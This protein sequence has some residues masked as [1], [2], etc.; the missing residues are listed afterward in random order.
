[1]TVHRVVRGFLGIA[2][3]LFVLGC[4]HS[5]P[6]GT[7]ESKGS[8][9][10]NSE[11][12][13]FSLKLPSSNWKELA[14]K[15]HLADFWNARFGSPM[16]AGVFSV[17]KQTKDEF[18]DLAKAFKEEAKKDADLLVKP[19]IQ[20]GV[21]EVGNAYIF[22]TLCEKGKGQE[23][24]IYVGRAYT[25]LKDKE[26]TV[27]VFFEGQGKMRSKVFKSIEYSEFEKAAKTICL[28]VDKAKEPDR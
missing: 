12:N 24:Y 15:K 4:G 8:W 1:M 20:E 13:G 5:K 9:V 2:L 16:L 18:E 3:A 6:A 10:Y 25:W 19:R 27:E 23:Q 21:N 17:K 22:E 11:T 7:D 28:S 14:K 26:L